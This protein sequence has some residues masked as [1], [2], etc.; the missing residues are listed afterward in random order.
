MEKTVARYWQ[1]CIEYTSPWAG[2]ELTTLVEYISLDNFNKK[3]EA[4]KGPPEVF[5]SSAPV[6]VTVDKSELPKSVNK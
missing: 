2:F 5:A 1:T 6:K 4:R 3:E